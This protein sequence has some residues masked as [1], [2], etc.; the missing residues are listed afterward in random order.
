MHPLL[1][2]L[3][4]RPQ[5]LID[6]AQG[7]VALLGEEFD[8]A[9]AAWQRRTLL[10]AAAL[11]FLAVALVLAGVALMLW[12]TVAT[13]VNVL[14]VLVSIPVLPLVVASVC[15]W[16]AQRPTQGESFADLRRQIN[17]DMALLRAAGKP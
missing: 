2:L 14:W 6:H 9:S 4:T 13:P 8:L 17:A 12:V 15:L 10:H 7:Y 3:A 16:L 11:C 5:L 1:T